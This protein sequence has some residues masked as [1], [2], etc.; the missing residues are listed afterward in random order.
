MDPETLTLMDYEAGINAIETATRNG[1]QLLPS[2]SELSAAKR[3]PEIPGYDNESAKVVMGILK[4]RKEEIKAITSDQEA[5]RKAL[6][7]G[8]QALLEAYNHA[9][10][11]LDLFDRLERAFRVVFPG[12]KACIHGEKGCP[13]ESIAFCSACTRVSHAS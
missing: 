13:E 9:G 4:R 7:K 1:I 12:T 11:Q 8:Q 3:M 10:V 5:T 2:G 6:C